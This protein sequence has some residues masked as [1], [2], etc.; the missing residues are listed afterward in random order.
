MQFPFVLH[1]V[2]A[3]CGYA[4]SAAD[5][6]THGNISSYFDSRCHEFCNKN[7]ISQQLASTCF[8]M[9]HRWK[10]VDDAAAV[11][12][13]YFEEKKTKLYILTS[14]DCHEKDLCTMHC[15]HSKRYFFFFSLFYIILN[16]I[17]ICPCTFACSLFFLLAFGFF[18]NGLC[19][20]V[21]VCF[22]LMFYTHT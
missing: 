4:V 2:C 1:K 13:Y 8:Y 21:C 22:F 3:A 10:K 20:C 12:F 9:F 16:L 19:V 11:F 6:H 17:L 15:A 18:L 5:I 7:I 14:K